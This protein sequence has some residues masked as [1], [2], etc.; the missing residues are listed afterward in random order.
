MTSKLLNKV[1][2]FI[3]ILFLFIVLTIVSLSLFSRSSKF[4]TIADNKTDILAPTPNASDKSGNNFPFSL[5][6][7]QIN[8]SLMQNQEIVIAPVEFNWPEEINSSLLK[9]GWKLIGLSHANDGGSVFYYY[10]KTKDVP[11]ISLGYHWDMSVGSF[12]SLSVN[13]IH[14]AK[15]GAWLIK[16]RP[17]F[18][19]S[20]INIES[21]MD[22][23]GIIYETHPGVTECIEK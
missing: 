2:I 19:N 21:L 20:S 9:S 14:P 15:I 5:S 4:N 23:Q 6:V 16:Y 1:F 12:Q 10:F 7:E 17:S 3:I 8:Q 22:C 18:E 11:A 13:F